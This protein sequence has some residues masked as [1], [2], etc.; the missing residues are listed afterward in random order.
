MLILRKMYIPSKCKKWEKKNIY[1][2]NC[3]HQLCCS[4]V[5]YSCICR[6]C[7]PVIFLGSWDNRMNVLSVVNMS[8]S[9][10]VPQVLS[11]P[12]GPQPPSR[13]CLCQNPAVVR[14]T[15]AA[16]SIV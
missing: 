13:L 15:L 11:E 1:M 2:Y 4:T 9:N 6:S 10:G 14:W 7:D 3:R 8:S 16:H 5:F 12:F